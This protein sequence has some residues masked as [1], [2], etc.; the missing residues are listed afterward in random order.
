MQGAASARHEGESSVDATRLNATTLRADACVVGTD[1]A[2]PR[3]ET[4][5]WLGVY[6]TLA[7]LLQLAMP[8]FFDADTGYHLAVARLT[9]THGVLHSFPWTSFSWLEHHY[10]DKELLFHWLLVPLSGLDPTWAA[11][12]AGTALG[13][14]LLGVMHALLRRER[15]DRA[16][17]WVLLTLASSSAFIWRFALVRPHMLSIPL[18]LLVLWA[19]T[20]R[21]WGVL[22]T[23]CLLF[24][25]CYTA[26]HLPVA[27]VLLAELARMAA[28]ERPDWR[29]L[30]LSLAGVGIGVSV[31]P[32]FPENLAFFWIQNFGVLVS[33]AWAGL[34][35][36]ELG[37]EFRPLSP[38]GLLRY[39]LVP[40]LLTG[41]ASVAGWRTRRSDPLGLVFATA[42]LGFV[43]LTLRTQRFIEYLAPLAV[44]AAAF[45]LRG[46]T[47]R[48]LPAGALVAA[49]VWMGSV[50]MHPF[51]RM[52]GRR[53]LFPEPV[54]ASLAQAIPPGTQLFTCDWEFTGE[55]MLALP[56]RRFLVALDPVFFARRNPHAYRVWFEMV[57][58]PPAEPAGVIRETFGA[59]FVLC[60]LRERWRPFLEALDGDPMAQRRMRVG[61]WNL[62]EILPGRVQS[63]NDAAA[64]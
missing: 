15:V 4:A 47:P 8:T 42:S 50:A 63:A 32:N 5:V 19:A 28:G 45:S 31:H 59:R 27:L 46:A 33:T 25:L 41:I 20:R 26:W 36:F 12:I 37:G 14:G 56:E 58:R 9:R 16:G 39:A 38:A 40:G 17:L 57:R 34:A 60:D 55:M 30:G 2:R 43:L 51:E 11:R 53:E 52:L 6:V 61:V 13:A 7:G 64:R 23:A 1:R 49:L 10:V 22:G 24:P 3:I 35:G 48:W 62:Y 44:L 29:P 21:S 18:A 54:A